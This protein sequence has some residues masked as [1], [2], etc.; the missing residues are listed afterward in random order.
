MRSSI[1]SRKRSLRTANYNVALVPAADVPIDLSG[2]PCR[3]NPGSTNTSSELAYEKLT[4]AV[5][6]VLG[7]TFC[8]PVHLG[9]GAEMAIASMISPGEEVLCNE[10]YLT[11]QWS[12]R[13]HGG[14]LCSLLDTEDTKFSGNLD[15]D[16]LA[17]RLSTRD[18]AYV[19]VTAP[20]SL[21]S[22]SG[23]A[24]VSLGNLHAVRSLIDRLSPDTPLILDAS[25]I[26]ENAAWIK[27]KEQGHNDRP[28]VE[29][30]REIASVADIVFLSGRKDLGAPAGGLIAF[31]DES[32]LSQLGEFV[33]IFEGSARTGGLL[34]AE[35]NEMASGLKSVVESNT[36][37]VGVQRLEGLAH[38]LID[39]GV[40]VASWGAGALYLDA[41]K[42]LPGI[43]V[44]EH[45]AQTLVNAL[46]LYAGIRAIGTPA[47]RQSEE[48]I[49]RL[50]VSEEALEYLRW[51]LPRLVPLLYPLKSGFRG[52]VG[53]GDGVF[54]DALEPVCEQEWCLQPHFQEPDLHITC[55]SGFSNSAWP[56]L[57][58][59]LRKVLELKPAH[60]LVPAQ[61]ERGA[62][63][64]LAEIARL[65]QPPYIIESTDQVI[66]RLVGYFEE[67]NL[68]SPSSISR[69]I[70][71]VNETELDEAVETKNNG[72]VIALDVG[73]MESWVPGQRPGHFFQDN[74]RID[75]IW[76]CDLIADNTGGGFVAFKADTSLYRVLQ[77]EMLFSVGSL[78][79]GGLPGTAMLRLAWLLDEATWLS[80]AR[81]H[82]PR[83][84][85]I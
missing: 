31:R 11:G 68:L 47:T 12:I 30:V 67:K 84:A 20:L 75:I 50:C 32:F 62:Q 69:R 28:L 42:W 35:I 40:P 71:V 44:V 41:R 15:L 23:G 63:R 74:E 59:V 55:R 2:H 45:P 5:D 52:S 80:V 73:P 1:E 79:D 14:N 25:R 43:P 83:I 85:W 64:L 61:R 81:R 49:I 36:V 58:S 53:G 76:S 4:Q 7:C 37:M 29:I 77:D 33:E 21:L 3:D 56:Q 24:P 38:Y 8:L 34:P 70:Y 48:Q 18:P 17:N 51:I 10:V 65:H 9:R 16:L 82:H 13:Q 39:E 27:L 19:Q 46:Y 66:Q 54:L 6:S 72:D 78:H 57:E 26:F 60:R 22:K